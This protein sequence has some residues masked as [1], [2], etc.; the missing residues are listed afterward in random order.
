MDQSEPTPPSGVFEIQVPS[1]LEGGT[2]ANFLSVWH[3][4]YEFTFDFAVTQPGERIDPN[5]QSSS[6][7]VPCRVVARLKIPPTLIFSVLQAL[8][9]NMTNYEAKFGEIRRLDQ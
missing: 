6:I 8:N 2:Y 4:P 5:D 7:R 9:E 3:T 1:E